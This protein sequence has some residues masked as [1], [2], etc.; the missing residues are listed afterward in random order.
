MGHAAVRAS[1]ESY[2]SAAW[3]DTP[4]AYD[5][6][7]FTPP[8][9]GRYVVASLEPGESRTAALGTPVTIRTEGRI[10]IDCRVPK[11]VG[12]A[13]ALAMADQIAALFRYVAVGAAR[14]RAPSIR[15]DGAA[16]EHFSAVVS[17]PYWFDE[18]G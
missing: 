13:G 3:T 8:E 4:I 16:A 6:V 9:D 18:T 10:V 1:V 17:V 7:T 11:G 14:T 5:N 12:S 2:L 15:L